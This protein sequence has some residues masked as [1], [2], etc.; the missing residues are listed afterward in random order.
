MAQAYRISAEEV[1]AHMQASRA[2][3]VLDARSPQAWS[4]SRVRMRGDIRINRD[5]LHIDLSSPK[6]QL[7]VVYCT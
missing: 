5:H 1:L 7:T 4:E 2:V 6:D 3:I